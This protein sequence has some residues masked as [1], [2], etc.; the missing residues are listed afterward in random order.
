MPFAQFQDMVIRLFVKTRK[1]CLVRSAVFAVTAVVPGACSRDGAPAEPAAEV[2][3]A[4]AEERQKTPSGTEV[5]PDAFQPDE[6]RKT[7][8]SNRIYYTLT[9]YPWYARGEPLLHDGR[10]HVASGLPI[11]ASTDEMEKAGEYEGVEFYT[12]RDHN[13]PVVYVPV[14]EGYWLGFRASATSGLGKSEQSL[15][16]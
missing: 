14:F 8:P 9:D 13:E 16:Q 10:P 4:N 3:A 7:L 2:T 12:R 1:W 11:A 6:D 5:P 15:A